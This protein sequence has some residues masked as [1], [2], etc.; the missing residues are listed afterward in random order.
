EVYSIE[1]DSLGRWT[2]TFDG[3]LSEGSYDYNVS[4][5]D[6]A[7]NTSDVMSGDF[8]IDVTPPTVPT[9]SL[10]IDSDTGEAGDNLT[11]FSSPYLEGQGEPGSIIVVKFANGQS[12]E[13]TVDQDGNWSLGVGPFGDG[14]YSYEVSAKDEVG[15][16]SEPVIGQISIDSSIP[17]L[18][19]GLDASFD[20]AEI[21][22][23]TNVNTPTFSGTSTPG[24]VLLLTINGQ[25]YSTTVDE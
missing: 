1:A 8:S 2:L 3:P 4:V 16:E 12:Y 17:P 20:S 11:K 18:T 25:E 10:S 24:L 23:V 22:N 9:V 19:G 21:D 15:N 5:T 6:K 13:T 7:G 14:T